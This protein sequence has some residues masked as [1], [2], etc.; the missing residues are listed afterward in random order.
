[1]KKAVIYADGASS[2]NPGVSGIG[3]VV[4][5]ENKTYE[6]SEHI[7]IATNNVA[8]YSALI[9]GLEKAAELDAESVEV[10]LDSELL[11]RQMTGAY[12]VKNENLIPLW[13]RAR[14]LSSS[15]RFFSISHIPRELNKQADKL[16]KKGAAPPAARL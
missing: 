1:M 3:V 5:L 14:E 13:R 11:V 9:R 12:K 8:E 15:F 4:A 16:A 7:G 2:G 10:F 6:I